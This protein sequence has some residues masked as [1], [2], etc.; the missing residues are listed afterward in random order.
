MDSLTHIA[1]GACIGEAFF[2]RKFGKKAML[3]GALAQSIPDIDFIAASWLGTAENL[4]AHRGFTHSLLFAVMVIPL[5]ALA[6]DK[7]HKPEAFTYRKLLLFFSIEVLL[8]LLLDGFNNYG[9]GWLEPFNHTRF[10]FNSMY[11]ADPFF[12]VWPGIAFIVL[13]VLNRYNM[14]RRFWWKFGLLLPFLYI[15]YCGVNKIIIS[16]KVNHLIAAQNIPNKYSFTTP[17]PL[18]NW[19]WYVVSGDENG[20]YTG[21][22]SVFDKSDTMQWEYFPRNE[23]LL[24]DQ[25][26]NKDVPL[27]KQFAHHFYTVEKVQDSI[28]FNDL[29]F[30]Q[31]VGWQ[32]PRGRFA[33]HYILQP[34][35]DNTLVVQRGRFAGWSWESFAVM[36]RR[37]RN[38]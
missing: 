24:K 21:Y 26:L 23:W 11:V 18:Q 34:A 20:F 9:V 32:D 16:K 15:C 6:V 1:L 33:F 7:I 37:I 14:R 25:A 17:A 3:W 4:L 36:W 8:H 22:L 10:S 31:V 38:P 12:S 29:R 13:L 30:G 27:L 35:A 5:F 2:E 28:L 19:L